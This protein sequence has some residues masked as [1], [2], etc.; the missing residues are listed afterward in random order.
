MWVETVK[1]SWGLI[2]AS[3]DWLGTC[4][5][6]S[7]GT[8]AAA[9]LL[10]AGLQTLTR[11]QRVRAPYS[12]HSRLGWGPACLI[13]RIT[14]RPLL[15]SPRPQ[16]LLC[17]QGARISHV[18]QHLGFSPKN[19]CHGEFCPFLFH[20]CNLQVK[21]LLYEHRIKKN[22]RRLDNY[23]SPGDF[24]MHLFYPCSRCTFKQHVLYP[25]IYMSTS[26]H[27]L[28]LLSEK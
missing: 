18:M 5:T 12:G 28:F 13:L 22:P 7:H 24:L 11:A 17:S 6:S 4:Q 3:S 9:C 19:C 27:Q 21:F 25:C 15:H 1:S 20:L 14:A 10:G 26:V 16:C 8:F 2:V 23:V